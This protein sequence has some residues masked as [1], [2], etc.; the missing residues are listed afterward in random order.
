MKLK[1]LR[2]AF[3][4]LTMVTI[5]ASALADT[6]TPKPGETLSRLFPNPKAW[7]TVCQLNKQAGKIESCDK[8]FAGRPLELPEGI[9]PREVRVAW[10]STTPA[11][12]QE[13]SCINLGAAP[14][15]RYGSMKLR[16]QGIDLSPVLSQSEKDEAK[17]LVLAGKGDK[18]LVTKDMVFKAMPFRS[19]DGSVKFVQNVRVCTPEQGGRPEVVEVWRLSTGKLV[20]DF[21]TCGN[22][23]VMREPPVVAK[24][25]PPVVAK[26]PP[27]ASEPPSVETLTEEQT[28][29]VEKPREVIT[30]VEEDEVLVQRYDWDLGFYIGLDRDV[31]YAGG[32]GAF[33]PVLAHRAWGRYAA[34]IGG[35]ANFWSG[36]TP[37]GYG[38]DGH[39]G[40]AG[41]A[42]K[43]SRYDGRDFGLKFPMWGAFHEHGGQAAYR[44]TRH[45]NLLC[46]SMA[47]TDASREK[48]GEKVLPEWQAWM[49][50]CDPTSQS[51][52][53]T[54]FGQ[55]AN[56]DGMRD[57]NYI[58][59][60]GGRVYLT[61]DLTGLGVEGGLAAELQPFVELGVNKT[62]P[63]PFSAHAYGG[64]RGVKKISSLG[65]GPHYSHAGTVLGATYNH[66]VGR[67]VKLS[68]DEERWTAM[69]KSLEALG[70][71]VD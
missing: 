28:P 27:A 64:L 8:I 47:Y 53:R 67:H 35:M 15:N 9:T 43:W 51:K 13:Q 10:R 3:A 54:V 25:E 44:E 32:E 26:S 18:R 50:F 49:S 7:Q 37:Q 1:L 21:E 56:T 48:A 40:A 57:I 42:Q 66:D 33:Y 65:V 30:P 2:L 6:Y 38:F 20:S 34:G 58:L 36:E 11:D 46:A 24:F 62:S 41:L 68:N 23:S 5:S 70:V 45:A 71:A 63:N 61:K 4:G 52:S 69:V 39:Y 16:L 12:V 55:T 29:V 17:R 19:R 60:A 31:K 59:S 14:F 22:M